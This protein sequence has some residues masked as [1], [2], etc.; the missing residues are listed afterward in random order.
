MIAE[1]AEVGGL[2]RKVVGGLGW[3]LVSQIV[4]QGARMAVAIVLAHLLTP[5]EFGL[6][7]MALV[8]SGLTTIFTDLSLSAALI[9][10]ANITEE[11]C[12]TVFWTT[13]G[14]G[15]AVAAVGIGL[16]PLVGRFFSTTAVTPLFAATAAGTLITALASTQMA[17]LTRAMDF[18]G[19]ELREIASTLVGAVAAIALALA[20]TGAWAIVGQG[21]ATGAASTAL[22]W[23]LS[24]W[25]P[26][27]LFSRTSLRTLG[28]FGA[29][30]LLARIFSYLNLSVDNLLIGRFLGSTALGV[31]SIAYNV[32]FFPASR[33]AQ[34]VQQ[35]LYAAF[36]RLQHEPAK[37]GQAWLR[38]NRVLTA[39]N[40][41][42]FLGMAVVAP[43][44]VPVVFGHRWHAAI[45]VLQLLSLAGVAQ[46]FQSLNWSVLQAVGQPGRLL[47]FMAF[48]SAITVGGFALGLFWGVL[49]VAG[50]F[51]VARTV[52]AV[53]YTRITCRT[54]DLTTGAFLRSVAGACVLSLTMAVAAYAA[55]IGMLHA[56]GGTVL[57]LLIV[58]IV[59]ITVYAAL[60][61]VFAKDLISE[62]RAA[63]RGRN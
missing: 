17:L 31:Y 12:S 11:D 23:R 29:K 18:R 50:L 4:A 52:V 36:V 37:L 43:D 1:K 51:A 60:L 46:S 6:A 53:V 25:R 33:I 21:L 24:R 62:T 47:R 15:T 26:R 40:V 55:R 9:Q 3:K 14:A 49:G 48:S 20:G 63:I 59:G 45:P 61:I 27:W 28:S 32:M 54:V 16:A 41:P 57:R 10:R 34:P 30:T 42:A 5:P 2:R 39:I 13:L 22:V 8:F 38:G 44:F 58:V 35:V 7:A 56:G 19:L